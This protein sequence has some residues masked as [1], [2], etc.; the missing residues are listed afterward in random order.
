MSSVVPAQSRLVLDTLRVQGQAGLTSL[1]ALEWLACFRLASV[2]HRLRAEGYDIETEMIDTASGK[3]IARYV[4]H[5][6]GG[7]EQMEMAL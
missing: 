3:R 2:V 5:E 1:Q 6:A 7:L 4:L